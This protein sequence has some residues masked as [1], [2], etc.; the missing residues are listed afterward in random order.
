[1][2]NIETRCRVGCR[3]AA[4]GWVPTASSAIDCASVRYMVGI[5][6]PSSRR[7]LCRS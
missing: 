7:T 3:R 5:N 2:G 6:F 4:F 1:M